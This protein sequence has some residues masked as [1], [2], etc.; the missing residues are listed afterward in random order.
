MKDK[1]TSPKPPVK[2]KGK[3]KP[4]FEL[5]RNEN[6]KPPARAKKR[7]PINFDDLPPAA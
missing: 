7:I 5:I 1:S 2:S 4:K 3:K 6:W